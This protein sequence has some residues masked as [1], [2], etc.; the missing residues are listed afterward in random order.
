[1]GPLNSQ[2]L[3]NKLRQSDIYITAS[4]ND[5]CSNSL[6]EA[7]SCGLPCLALKSGG[8]SEIVNDDNFLFSTKEELLEK[9]NNPAATIL[10]V[11]RK[12]KKPKEVAV[13]YISFFNT[14]QNPQDNE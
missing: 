9:V 8:H 7:L 12:I 5:P 4:Q 11:D 13:K 10:P 6:I 3:A 2:N 14:L 1:M